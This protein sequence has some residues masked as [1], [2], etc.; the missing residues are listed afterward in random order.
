MY[1][2]YARV[3]VLSSEGS[4]TSPRGA[5]ALRHGAAVALW[6]LALGDVTVKVPEAAPLGL[7]PVSAGGAGARDRLACAVATAL[8]DLLVYRGDDAV[9]AAAMLIVLDGRRVDW[10]GAMVHVSRPMRVVS[11][12]MYL[13]NRLLHSSCSCLGVSASPARPVL[14][15][16]RAGSISSVSSLRT[17]KRNRTA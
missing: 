11:A 14:E 1:Y 9:A 2:V 13:L 10:A 7:V 6:Q 5:Q 4:P 8:G 17:V 12:A 3:L 16:E 15:M